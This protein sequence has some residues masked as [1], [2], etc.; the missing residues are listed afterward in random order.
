[1]ER[2]TKMLVL[3]EEK[4]KL[5]RQKEL[6]IKKIKSQQKEKEEGMI[7]AKEVNRVLGRLNQIT[8]GAGSRK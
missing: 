4:A 1:M 3:N 5:L 8:G 6:L 7:Y 2:Q